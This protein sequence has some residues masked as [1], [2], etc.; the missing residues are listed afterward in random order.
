MTNQHINYNWTRVL[1]FVDFHRIMKNY[2]LAASRAIYTL[3]IF[4]TE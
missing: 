3:W 2:M 4:V 1:I